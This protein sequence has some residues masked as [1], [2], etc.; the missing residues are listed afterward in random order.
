[1]EMRVL[2][3]TGLEVSALCLGAM[4]FGNETDENVAE[5]MVDLFLEA[6]GNF[7]DTA[8][9]Y[10]ASEDMTGRLLSGRRDRVVLATKGRLPMGDDPHESG[11]SRRYLTQAVE[12][13]LRRLGTDWIDLYQVHCPDPQTP[14]EET[15]GALDS[16]VRSGKV[17]YA[18]LSNYT[19][20]GLTRALLQADR[21]G[22]A[23][24]VAHQ[25]QYSLVHREIEYE[26]LPLC[27][28][29]RIA[30]LAWSPLAG[31]VLT[32]KYRGA[33]ETPSGTR[34][35]ESEAL[36]SRLLNQSNLLIADEVSKVAVETGR[37]PAQVAL[38]WVLHQPGVT[39][40]ILGVRSLEQLR[41]N[42]GA[43]GWRLEDEH[44]TRLRRASQRP[45][46]YP[47][48]MYERLGIPTSK[49]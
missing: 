1:M 36:A 18:G 37:T 24:I 43:E 4:T 29:N 2:G 47:F 48:D 12:R 45:L 26:T 27:R 17:R 11:A 41:D 8:D 7:V 19:G 44:V 14:L 32:G 6:G 33:G 10:L 34:F 49:P 40:P 21:H 46:P 23:P 16:M 30:V 5:A 25:A 20:S 31:G 15:L 3:G 39:S 22:W 9:V 28:E 13:S 38:N 35:G 42:L